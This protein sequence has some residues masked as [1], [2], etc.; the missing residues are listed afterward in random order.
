VTRGERGCIG[1]LGRERIDVA[2][3]P[4]G[5]IDPASTIGAGDVFAAACFLALAEGAPFAEA[6]DRANRT[7]AAH[8]AR[9]PEPHPSNP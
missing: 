4:L 5:A 8:V 3:I 1:H 7:A 9:R 6:L 2:G